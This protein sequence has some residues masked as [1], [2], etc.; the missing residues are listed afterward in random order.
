MLTFMVSLAGYSQNFPTEF[1]GIPVDGT[2]T[3]MINA[4]KAKG[5][6][7]NSVNDWMTGQFNGMDVIVQVLTNK[8][9]VDRIFVFN[10]QPF[11]EQQIK[12]QYNA[13][14][15]QFNNNKKYV[16]PAETD[17]TIPESEDISYEIT[18]NNKRY[19]AQY[20]Q[21]LNFNDF[22]KYIYSR[23]DSTELANLPQN[24]QMEKIKKI[25]GNF[26]TEVVPKRLVWFIISRTYGRY[27]IN[28]FYDNEYNRPNG[29]DL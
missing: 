22:S 8:N 28:L 6:T 16:N 1:M 27:Y 29:E 23:I 19:E 3:H 15:N 26:I 20:Y 21:L 2:K 11:E 24:E 25:S 12:S 10:S 18:V 4:L 14:V 13:L 7:Y 17:Y 5:F 9:K